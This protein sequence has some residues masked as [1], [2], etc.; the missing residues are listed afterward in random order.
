M[1]EVSQAG[2]N[3]GDQAAAWFARLRADNVRQADRDRFARWLDADPAHASAY[4]DY[5]ALWVGLQGAAAD[6]SIVAMR[7]QAL[8]LG[9]AREPWPWQKLAALAATVAIVL[10]AGLM[11]LRPT[12]PPA[13][14]DGQERPAIAQADG[15]RTYRTEVGQ[16]TSIRLADGS[17]V[18]LNT[19]SVLEV[20]I[21]ASHRN[22]RLLRGEA[23]F[24]VAHD[25]SRPFVVQAGGQRV[26]ALG[27]RFEV[28][29]RA[30]E[31]RVTLV[32]GRVEVSRLAAEGQKAAKADEVRQL[33][34]GE[35]LI[36]AAT[37][38]FVVR[39][40]NVDEALSWRTGR[41]T[42]TDEPLGTVVEEIN[43]YSTRRVVLGDPTLAELRVSGVFRTGSVGDFVAALD[44]GF[45]VESRVDQASDTIVLSWQ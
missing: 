17:T 41:L 35:L 2:L 3:A 30:S 40:T 11:L 28:D 6:E 9:R 10:I 23:L 33:R 14:G 19:A 44:A 24:D 13:A 37:Q 4:S 15:V 31:T 16:R 36:A 5:E 18:D 26:V 20:D 43:R 22:L 1:Q 27:T 34:P 25:A 12:L 7:Q 32:E 42:F 8:A 29:V 45:P 39:T 21:G 38:P